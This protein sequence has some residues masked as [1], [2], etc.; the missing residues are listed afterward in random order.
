MDDLIVREMVMEDYST[1]VELWKECDLPYKPNGRDHPDSIRKEMELSQ[2]SFLVA[3]KHGEIIGSILVTHDGRKG[4][5][6]RLAVHSD[7]RNKGVARL[8]IDEAE[9]WLMEQAIEIFACLIE[10]DNPESMKVIESLG[11]EEFEGVRYFTKRNRPD[12]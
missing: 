5:I 8:L 3:E 1:V 12:I 7:H 2:N 11:Y 10:G 6:N 9:K 4:W